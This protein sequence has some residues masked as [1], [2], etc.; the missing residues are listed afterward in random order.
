MP[1]ALLHSHSTKPGTWGMIIVLDGSLT[2]R[3]LE[4]SVEEI[5]LSPD[6]PGVIEP[7]VRHELELNSEARFYVQFYV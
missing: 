4:P 5:R 2:Y 7:A 3:I 6:R 1:K